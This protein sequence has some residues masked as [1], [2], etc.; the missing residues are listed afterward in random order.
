MK[1]T[2]SASCY[3]ASSSSMTTPDFFPECACKLQVEMKTSRTQL[4][5]GRRFLRCSNKE[6]QCGFFELVDPEVKP[7]IEDDEDE[8]LN[9]WIGECYRLGKYVEEDMK[10]IRLLENEVRL[11]RMENVESSKCSMKKMV[12]CACVLGVVCLVIQ[13]FVS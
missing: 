10:R 9:F 2:P 8:K 7:K 5:P 13:A 3:S 4:N 12:A 11:L 6:K 1:F